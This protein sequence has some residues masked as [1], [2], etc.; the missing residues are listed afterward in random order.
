MHELGIAFYIIDDVKE[1]VEKNNLTQVG[2]VTIELG[3]V[4]GVIPEYLEDVWNW[5]CEKH[6]CM[7]G[8]KL[9][10]LKDEAVTFCEDCHETYPTVKYGKE[11]PYCHSG[12]TY[13]VKGNG[14]V[15]KEIEAC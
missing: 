3:E 14:A 2:S 15:I 10:I 8:C 6:E 13:L 4:S 9:N 11:C 5:A 7:K 1:V 12:N